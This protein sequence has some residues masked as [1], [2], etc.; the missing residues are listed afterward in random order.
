MKRKR[1]LTNFDTPREGIFRCSKFCV[2][3]PFQFFYHRIIRVYNYLSINTTMF[4]S[5]H[6]LLVPVISVSSAPQNS[7]MDNNPGGGHKEHED[8]MPVAQNGGRGE[9]VGDGETATL[10]MQTSIPDSRAIPDSSFSAP[11]AAHGGSFSGTQPNGGSSNSSVGASASTGHDKPPDHNE[12]SDSGFRS[13][14]GTGDSHGTA[15]SPP[16]VKH[17]ENKL[18]ALSVD[19]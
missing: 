8:S 17:L 13:E 19:N 3:Q 9:Y 10:S 11:S 12:H 7:C 14:D 1:D 5:P 2:L 16:D 4:L 6:W 15:P 18:H